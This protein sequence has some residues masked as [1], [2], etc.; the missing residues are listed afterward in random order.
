METGHQHTLKFLYETLSYEDYR[1][2]SRNVR[3]FW[4]IF[5][6]KN[7][8]AKIM[9]RIFERLC[10]RGDFQVRSEIRYPIHKLEMKRFIAIIQA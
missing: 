9:Q 1:I 6:S 4:T 10:F 5:L 2:Y 7:G 8:K 3:T